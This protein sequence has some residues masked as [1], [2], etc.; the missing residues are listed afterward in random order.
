[1]Q[2]IEQMEKGG[3][4]TKP[5]V[6]SPNSVN[7]ENGTGNNSQSH[8][9]VHFDLDPEEVEVPK[10]KEQALKQQKMVEEKPV[11]ESVVDGE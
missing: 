1:M 5:S 7:G 10:E 11:A 6:S 2:H 4:P 3:E 9:K 8:E